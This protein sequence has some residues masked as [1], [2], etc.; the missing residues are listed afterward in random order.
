MF[1]DIFYDLCQEAGVTPT[2]VAREL[3]IRQST[4]SMWKKQGTTPKYD[5][6]KKLS[7]FF[8]VSVDYLHGTPNPFLVCDN[9]ALRQIDQK[10]AKKL[11]EEIIDSL[12]EYPY[13]DDLQKMDYA[14]Y[15]LNSKGRKE[16]V[17]RVEE[18]TEITRYRRQE[19]PQPPPPAPEGTDTTPAAPPPESAEE[20]E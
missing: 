9:D 11:S 19:P 3:G 2:Q 1:Y 14:L 15:K 12:K 8:G 10:M 6:L 17:K 16:A 18:L 13:Y 5:T 7:D 4:V 20:G